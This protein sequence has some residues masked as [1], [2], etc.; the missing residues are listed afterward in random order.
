[1]VHGSHFESLHWL[2]FLFGKEFQSLILRAIKLCWFLFALEL[3]WMNFLGWNC[4]VLFRLINWVMPLS[5]FSQV[6]QNFLDNSRSGAIFIF[7]KACRSSLLSLNVLHLFLNVWVP[8]VTS[9][10]KSE[11]MLK[12][13]R[14]SQCF[15]G[16]SYLDL[17]SMKEVNNKS[18]IFS[19]VTET[20]ILSEIVYLV[21][22]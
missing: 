10:F 21:T 2:L 19:L 8:W 20:C 22:W 16:K 12:E 13:D 3:T 14:L 11:V 5:F 1:M 18:N 7:N 9:T 17:L 15:L 6:S 4:L